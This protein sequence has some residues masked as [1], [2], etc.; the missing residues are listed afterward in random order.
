MPLIKIIGNDSMQLGV[1][2][3][4]M[5]LPK[6]IPCFRNQADSVVDFVQLQPYAGKEASTKTV[7][8]LLTT[9]EALYCLMICYDEK[10]NI[11]KNTGKLDDFGGDIVSLMLDTFGDRRTAYKF[12]VT[13]S[14]VRSDCRLLD[15][16]ELHERRPEYDIEGNFVSDRLRLTDRVGVTKVKYLYYF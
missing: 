1:F 13:A 10:K 8:K 11:Q 2:S 15:D 6:S 3:Y 5:L 4:R 12:A 16:N 7:A 9:D 14:G